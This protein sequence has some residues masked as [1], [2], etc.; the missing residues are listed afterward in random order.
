MELKTVSPEISWSGINI[1][2][3]TKLVSKNSLI[4]TSFNKCAFQSKALIQ[5]DHFLIHYRQEDTETSNRQY[6]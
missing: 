2:M 3:R 1:L 4:P 6:F 5:A